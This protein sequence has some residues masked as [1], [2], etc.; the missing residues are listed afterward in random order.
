MTC[1]FYFFF[2]YSTGWWL[3]LRSGHQHANIATSGTMPPVSRFPKQNLKSLCVSIASKIFIGNCKHLRNAF[4]K[5]SLHVV[6]HY[7]IL[8][9]GSILN[10][11]KYAC[12]CLLLFRPDVCQTINLNVVNKYR[13]R[14]TDNFFVFSLLCRL[15]YCCNYILFFNSLEITIL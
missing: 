11:S 14:K 9:D 15:H 12:I 4:D 2:V 6:L 3:C 5:G 10:I 1:E 13:T 7:S 8:K